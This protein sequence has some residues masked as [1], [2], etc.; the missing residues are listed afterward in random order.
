MRR[1]AKSLGF[2]PKRIIKDKL[3]SYW[4]AKR[5]IAPGL[6][7]WS[8]NGFN[9]R[10]ENSHLP[11]RK[12]EGAMQGYWSPGGLQRFAATHSAIR[13]CFNVPARRCPALTMTCSP[14]KPSI[15]G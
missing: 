9:N 15:R 2:I 3:V 5:E 6:R 7:H 8:H 12:Q 11:F 4:A 1:L 13:D 14:E 10:A